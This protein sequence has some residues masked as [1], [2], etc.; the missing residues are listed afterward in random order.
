[1]KIRPSHLIT[2]LACLSVPTFFPVLAFAG[3]STD[4]VQSI[5]IK[6][7]DGTSGQV[8]HQ[9]SGVKTP[10]IQDSAVTAAKISNGAVT[11]TKLGSDVA[12]RIAALEAQIVTLTTRLIAVEGNAALQLG[13]YVSVQ[14][15]IVQG[16][17]GPNIVFEGVN[18]HVRNGQGGESNGLGNLILGYNPL[19]APY[20]L[21]VDVRT[22]SHN[23][24]T[25]E[26]N[27][28][29]SNQGIIAGYFNHIQ[30]WMSTI[31]GGRGNFTQGALD[32]IL[33]G[34][35]N[36]TLGWYTTIGGGQQNQ[37][38]GEAATVTGGWYND[39]PGKWSS[40]SG[41]SWNNASGESSSIS[42]GTGLTV[43]DQNGWAP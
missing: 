1:M 4:Q 33:G 9:G 20:S 7:A 29:E 38:S 35:A 28:Y 11:N 32:S 16:A 17:P 3:V 15:G 39:A 43:M 2:I 41:G 18:V 19:R 26:F 37:S 21:G 5:H 10:H 14:S 25:G 34:Y 23:F 24:I 22:G 13:P 31:L 8:A 40:V 12:A 6:E 30:G 27:N 42:G 36:Q